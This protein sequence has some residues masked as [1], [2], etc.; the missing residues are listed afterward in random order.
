MKLISSLIAI[1]SLSAG[2]ALADN[3]GKAPNCEV[4]KG[5][6]ATMKH[7]ADE[8]ACT[9][10]KGKWIATAP[11]ADAAAPAAPAADA[12]A[13]AAAPAHK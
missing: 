9:K 12:A 7:V 13:P 8:A 6:K 11:A 10:A 4:M 3:H 2:V 1:V 5:K